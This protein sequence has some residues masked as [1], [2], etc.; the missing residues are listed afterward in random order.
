M[1]VQVVSHDEADEIVANPPDDL[2]AVVSIHSPPNS[3]MATWV[4][5]HGKIRTRPCLGFDEFEGHKIAL[6]FDDACVEGQ[7]VF[8]P[9]K[10]HIQAFIDWA[11][12]VPYPA[13]GTI[14]I[15]CHAGIAR[16]TACALT[17]LSVHRGPG[18]ERECIDEIFAGRLIVWHADELLGREQALHNA[19]QDWKAEQKALGI[20]TF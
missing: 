9:E 7:D 11:R 10:H 2:K 8:I 17:F 5:T 12:T 20:Y 6:T 16:S 3:R 4:N 14:L 15:H 18:T 1:K 19:E 13:D